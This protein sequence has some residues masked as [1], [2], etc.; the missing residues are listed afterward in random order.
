MCDVR[1]SKQL[2]EIFWRDIASVRNIISRLISTTNEGGTG[3]SNIKKHDLAT[4]EKVTTVTV[5]GAWFKNAIWELIYY[6]YISPNKA[7][8]CKILNRSGIAY[9]EVSHLFSLYEI[10]IQL[11]YYVHMCVVCSGGL[12]KAFCLPWPAEVSLYNAKCL[13]FCFG[14]C[15]LELWRRDRWVNTDCPA[16]A[17]IYDV[18][19]K[20]RKLNVARLVMSTSVSPHKRPNKNNGYAKQCSGWS[21]IS[22]EHIQT[23]KKARNHAHECALSGEKIS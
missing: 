15:R 18:T 1:H 22:V 8:A 16:L 3:W 2:S 11:K 5:V 7:T 4:G 6:M 9:K 10:E 13:L 20:N 19:V 12:R 21:S 17:N 23:N 14:R